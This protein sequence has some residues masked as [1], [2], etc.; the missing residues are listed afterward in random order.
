MLD[1]V[2]CAESMSC[3]LLLAST[4]AGSV[5][6]LTQSKLQLSLFSCSVV[7]DSWQPHGL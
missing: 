2:L 5:P 7:S 4:K 3:L 6:A 1:T